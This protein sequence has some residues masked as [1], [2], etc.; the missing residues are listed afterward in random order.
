V[1][2]YEKARSGAKVRVNCLA[3]AEIEVSWL[4]ISSRE[5]I[6]SRTG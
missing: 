3:R 2:I 5:A 6:E 4:A 1:G